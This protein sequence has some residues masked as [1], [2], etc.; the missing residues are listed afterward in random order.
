MQCFN[1]T[2]ALP[3]ESIIQQCQRLKE[4]VVFERLYGAVFVVAWLLRQTWT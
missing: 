3:S 4:I 1:K 2:D